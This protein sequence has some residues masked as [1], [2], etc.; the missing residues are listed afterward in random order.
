MGFESYTPKANYY[1]QCNNFR[2]EYCPK[3]HGAKIK[4]ADCDKQN[5]KRLE[6]EQVIGHLKGEKADAS[7]V[8]GKV[9]I[10][11]ADGIYINTN[12]LLDKITI[13]YI[14]YRGY[15]KRIHNR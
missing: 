11:L 3:K 8:A 6:K 7:D 14:I 10:V 5:Y 9:Q 1:P 13:E 2:K 12:N 15:E 4:C